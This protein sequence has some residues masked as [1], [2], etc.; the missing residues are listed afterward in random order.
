MAAA[1]LFP[2]LFFRFA[3][4]FFIFPVLFRPSPCACL[5][6]CS[7]LIVIFSI[8]SNIRIQCELGYQRCSPP[9]LS[10]KVLVVSTVLPSSPFFKVTYLAAPTCWARDLAVA[11][12]VLVRDQSRLLS[13]PPR[14]L[15][16]SWFVKTRVVFQRHSNQPFPTYLTASQRC[17]P[18]FRALG[19][20]ENSPSPV[21]HRRR[22]CLR[23]RRRRR[24]HSICH[25]NRWI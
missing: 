16:S 23:L 1:S 19:A 20:T 21:H 9:T 13:T 8:P 11:V 7:S 18:P 14:S 3:L 22:R 24:R 17:G 2:C 4:P 5:S 25:C 10:I 12:V 6:H 15:S